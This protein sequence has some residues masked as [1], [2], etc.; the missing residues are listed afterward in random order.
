MVMALLGFC[1]AIDSMGTN[2]AAVLRW[3]QVPHKLY[4]APV[5]RGVTAYPGQEA[6][7]MALDWVGILVVAATARMD[8]PK[9]AAGLLSDLTQLLYCHQRPP[10][11][12]GMEIED[13]SSVV[14]S[15]AGEA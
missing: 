15:C 10:G 8:L 11:K 1:L 14:G 9:A 13:F 4:H 7:G 12:P 5:R 6:V 3:P 2:E